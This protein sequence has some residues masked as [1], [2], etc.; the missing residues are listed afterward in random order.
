MQYAKLCASAYGIWETIKYRKHYLFWVGISITNAHISK[1]KYLNQI[2]SLDSKTLISI[3]IFSIARKPFTVKETK[4]TNAFVYDLSNSQF[5][6]KT[7][8][9]P[10][11]TKSKGYF[12]DGYN[13]CTGKDL[14]LSILGRF[15]P[16]WKQKHFYHNLLFL[17]DK[18]W[19]NI[20]LNS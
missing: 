13:S 3:M 19:V 18:Y 1:I 12:F 16:V 20:F 9:I 7:M 11:W 15:S 6:T 17:F 10:A 8:N 2:H 4:Q 5:Y 14:F